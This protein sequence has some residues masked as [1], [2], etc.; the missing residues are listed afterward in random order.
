MNHAHSKDLPELHNTANVLTIVSFISHYTVQELK[1][2]LTG[3]TTLL[4]KLNNNDKRSE[5]VPEADS[6]SLVV[7]SS[8]LPYFCWPN[9]LSPQRAPVN[10]QRISSP[11][12]TDSEW[13]KEAGQGREWILFADHQFLVLVWDIAFDVALQ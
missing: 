7:S 3:L 1:G 8:V 6:A 5:V 9:S 12:K 11:S 13:L 4:Q 10:A 2:F